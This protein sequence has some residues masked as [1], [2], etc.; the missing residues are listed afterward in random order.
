VKH[1]GSYAFIEYKS[2]KEAGKA[3]EKLHK[4]EVKGQELYIEWGKGTKGYDPDA[5]L[6][7]PYLRDRYGNSECYN[8]HRGG[9]FARDCPEP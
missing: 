6:N 5:R 3:L 9:H 1:K 8:C 7:R 2:E 4:K